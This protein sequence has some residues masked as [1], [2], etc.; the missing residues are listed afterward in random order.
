MKKGNQ[1]YL[2]MEITDDNNDTLDITNVEKIQFNIGKIIKTYDGSSDEVKYNEMNNTFEIFLTEEDTFSF[3]EEIEIDA[4]ILY[5]N[6]TIMGTY[7]ISEYVYDSVNEVK[8]DVE[9]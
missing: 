3:S 7:I 8:L 5:N 6:N 4:R 9:S 1:F 2:I